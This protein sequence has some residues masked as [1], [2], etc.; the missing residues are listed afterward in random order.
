MDFASLVS[1]YLDYHRLLFHTEK[2]I[3]CYQ[4]VLDV[5]VRFL[6]E[7]GY[8]SITRDVLSRYQLYLSCKGIKST[9]A[10]SY[11]A[12]VKAFIHWLCD[13]GYIEDKT[14]Y[15]QIKMPKLPKK[16]VKIYSDSE[17]K[18]IFD[19]VSSTLPWL[20]ARNKLIISLMYDSGL[21]Q[22]EVCNISMNDLDM[23]SFMLH[24]HGKGNKDRIVPIGS[25][26]LQ[27]LQEYLNL[28]PFDSNMLLLSRSGES[29]TGNAIKLFVS[30]LKNKLGFE[31]SSHKLRHNFATN[32][33]IDHHEKYG[34]FDTYTLMLLLGH[35][36][37]STT[38][39]YLHLA[40]Q[41]LAKNQGVSH[42]DKI[43]KI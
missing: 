6:A 21:R 33:L 31:F 16:N 39:K 29:L 42:L 2:T 28:R 32:F 19:S 20:T 15:Q 17:I 41:Y 27:L 37:I 30:K 1:M 43:Y 9:S 40:K 34:Y 26:T 3:K 10:A 25:L 7:G 5:F 22:S 36:E 4:E 35:E 14:L 8:I 12:H 23:H 11:S 18:L 24:V 38:D 13:N